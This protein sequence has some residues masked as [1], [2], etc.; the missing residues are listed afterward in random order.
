M[1]RVF[2]SQLAH[3]QQQA[4]FGRS[5]GTIHRPGP[6][7][8]A[9]RNM[10]HAAVGAGTQMG[11]HRA[12]NVKRRVQVALHDLVPH[13]GGRVCQGQW[14]GHITHQIHTA[15]HAAEFCRR[16]GHSLVHAGGVF[17]VDRKQVHAG[18][19][20]AFNRGRQIQHRHLRAGMHGRLRHGTA[21]AA[22]AAHQQQ[23]LPSLGQG[24]GFQFRHRCTPGK[25]CGQLART[26]M[27]CASTKNGHK[28]VAC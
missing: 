16:L 3:Q 13:I 25:G 9:R 14:R 28:A 24:V 6:S 20:V 15:I 27:G 8:Q 11:H 12:R 18:Q 5:I 4:C 10:H 21:Y 22:T 17:G 1:G 23:A 19:G 2:Q 26:S 7:A